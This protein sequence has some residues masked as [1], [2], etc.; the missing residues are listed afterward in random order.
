MRIRSL[1]ITM[2]G[3]AV[4]GASVY[5]SREFL[6]VQPATAS[7]DASAP[8]LVSVVVAGQ[9]IPFG[10]TIEA[11]KLTTI[12]WPADAVPPG[13]FRDYSTLLPADGTEPRRAKRA[14]SQGEVV[15]ANKISD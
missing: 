14:M 10:T 6:Q 11:H 4:A 12:Q 2:V 9:D 13:T 7:V 3:M 15:L 8:A 1:F 5:A